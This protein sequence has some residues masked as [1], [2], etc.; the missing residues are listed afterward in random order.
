MSINNAA[1]NIVVDR[2]KTAFL[3]F[4]WLNTDTPV[5]SPSPVAPDVIKRDCHMA[6][7]YQHKICF[8]GHRFQQDCLDIA[9][10]RNYVTPSED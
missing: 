9:Q 1:Q 4:T 6:Y 10:G 8:S 5:T 2:L 3:D 7:I